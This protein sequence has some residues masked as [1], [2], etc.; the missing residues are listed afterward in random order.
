MT[1]IKEEIPHCG[2]CPKYAVKNNPNV[3]CSYLYFCNGKQMGGIVATHTS[4]NGC[5]FHPGARAYLNK[6]VIDK[7]SNM[8]DEFGDN[9]TPYAEG[10]TDALIAIAA[11]MRGD[12]K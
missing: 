4:D 11:L 5:L 7:M 1:E 12:G 6:D 10:Y 3:C 2:N 9:T 8:L